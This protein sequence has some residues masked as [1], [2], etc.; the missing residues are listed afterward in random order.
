MIKSNDIKKIIYLSETRDY[1]EGEMVFMDYAGRVWIA[2]L[3]KGTVP[4][5]TVARYRTLELEVDERG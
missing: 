4:N 5:K 2:K 1:E 3:S